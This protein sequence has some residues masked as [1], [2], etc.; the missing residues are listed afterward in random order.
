M[1]LLKPYEVFIA[2]R[3]L[4]ARR[5][6]SFMGTIA[7]VSVGGVVVGVAALVI[8]LAVMNG[9]EDEV[10]KRIVGTNAHVIVLGYNEKGIEENWQ[11][12]KKINSV[13]GV[14]A[15]S[16]FV[17]AKVMLASEGGSEGAV[18]KGVN[19]TQERSV[20]EIAQ[21]L[22]PRIS[23]IDREGHGPGVVVGKELA[24]SLG[25]T[26]G[27]E[28][29][30]VSPFSGGF[31]PFGFMPKMQK[32]TVVSIF[33]SGMYEYDSSF[34]FVTLSSAQKLLELGEAV[35]GVEV[36]IK[37]MMD[38]PRMGDRI[39]KA[40]GGYPFRT[41]NWIELNRN[42]FAWMKM[43]KKVMFI[44]LTLIVLV[45][46]FN[47]RNMLMMLVMEKR[48]DIGV[49]RSLGVTSR[50]IMRIFVLQGLI[51]GAVGTFFGGVIGVLISLAIGKY[52]FIELPGDIYFIDTLP[53]KLEMLDLV[54]IAAAVMLISF[55]ATLHPSRQASRLVPV[56]AIRY[57]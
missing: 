14:V 25:L 56:E 17:Y 1:K 46:A 39:L 21:N 7:A 3:Y 37:E 27:D 22:R 26:I 47:I 52:K 55:I 38:A 29:R 31:S 41:N 13:P 40:L 11:I 44:I 15:S 4:T 36:K 50:G 57:E 51:V 34:I 48:R 19:L 35:T 12:V 5:K 2:L 6:R 43:E 49:L 10:Q 28:L 53:I 9:F 42:L 18:L 16:P 30:V 32:F 20:T 8:V 54:E 45:A 23:A 33:D 24:A